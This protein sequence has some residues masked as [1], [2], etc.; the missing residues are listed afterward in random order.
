MRKQDTGGALDSTQR[1]SPNEL[2]NHSTDAC[3]SNVFFR[4]SPS[5]PPHLPLLVL[6]SFDFS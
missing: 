2:A 1:R 5:L 4:D 3:F 6:L